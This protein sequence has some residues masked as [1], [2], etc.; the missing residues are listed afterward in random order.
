MK[1][2]KKWKMFAGIVAFCISWALLY[3][4]WIIPT[5]LVK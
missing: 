2:S 1:L 5:F 4:F 3:I